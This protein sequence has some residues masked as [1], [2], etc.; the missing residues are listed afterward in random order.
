MIS[1]SFFGGY[2]WDWFFKGSQ[3]GTTF[4]WVLGLESKGKPRR[5]RHVLGPA[6]LTHA[7]LELF[8]YPL[9]WLWRE[10][11]GSNPLVL[12]NDNRNSDTELE[13]WRGGDMAIEA[14]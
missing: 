4:F 6:V 2:R 9:C 5:K 7:V 1:A 11:K 14:T 13:P 12:L 8:L 10:T 3:E